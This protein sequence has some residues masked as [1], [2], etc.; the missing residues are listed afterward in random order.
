MSFTFFDNERQHACP[1]CGRTQYMQYG[2]ADPPDFVDG[3]AV[4]AGS[5]AGVRR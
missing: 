2:G 3:A 5:E 1:K 4:E